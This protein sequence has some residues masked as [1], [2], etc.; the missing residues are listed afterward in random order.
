VIP[1]TGIAADR[2]RAAFAEIPARPP[3][4]MEKGA[5][6]WLRHR[7]F[8]TWFDALLTVAILYVAV[9]LIPPFVEWAVLDAIWGPAPPGDCRV[10][11]AGACWAFVGEKYRLIFFGL[12]PYEEQWRPL[13]AM[14]LLIGLAVASTNRRFWGRWLVAAWVAVTLVALTLMQGALPIPGFP[15]AIPGLT[16]VET[17][18]WGGL[19]LTVGLSMIGLG[20]AF[21]FAILL[22]LGRQATLPAIRAMCVTYIELIRGVPLITIL[23]MAALLFPLFMPIGVDF[24]YLLRVQ[25]GMILFAAAYLAEVVRGGLQA[26]PKGQYEA[27]DSLGLRYWSKQRLIVLPQALRISIPPLVNTFIGFFKDTTLVITVGLY[28]ILG[29]AKLGLTD[30]PWGSFYKEAYL[31]VSVVFFVFCFSMSKY[32]QYLE[33]LLNTGRRR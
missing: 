30:A 24:N 13:L 10:D 28:D 32:S 31:F 6:G 4:R 14:A 21:P 9:R 1:V 33:K 17:A 2:P 12:Y 23:F 3:P 18:Q 29:A 5:V 26:I 15:I 11:G 19:P 22:A 8:G 16:Y 20:L 27:A 25:V 7:L